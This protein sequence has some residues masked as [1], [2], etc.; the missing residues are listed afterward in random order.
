MLDGAKRDGIKYGYNSGGAMIIYDLPY[1][2]E[3][4]AQ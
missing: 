1:G 2:W 3:G 4:G